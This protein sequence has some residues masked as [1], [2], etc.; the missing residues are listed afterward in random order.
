MAAFKLV[1]LNCHGLRDQSKRDLLT[2]F[3]SLVPFDV[4]FFQETH[5]ADRV[6]GDALSRHFGC[7]GH[8]SFGT[9]HSCGVGILFRSHL[10]VT[11]LVSGHDDH[12]RVVW[13][14]F[15]LQSQRFRFVNVYAPNVGGDRVLFFNFVYTLLHSNRVTVLGGDFNCVEDLGLDKAGGAVLAGALGSV[16]LLEIRRDFNLVDAF[17]HLY[18]AGREYTFSAQGV[19][20]RLDRFYVSRGLLSSVHAVAHVH[21]PYS[22]HS[23]VRLHF[24][25]SVFSAYD[26]GP[27]YWKCN[28]SVLGDSALR[29][30]FL[31]VWKVCV[32]SPVQDGTWWEGCKDRFRA[33]LR[34]HSIRLARERFFR[35]RDL[36]GRVTFLRGIAAES[37]GLVEGAL[38]AAEEE[39]GFLLGERAMGARVRARA[40]LLDTEERPTR[41]FFRTEAKHARSRYIDALYDSAG[42]LVRGTDRVVGACLSYYT[43]L[44]SAQPTVGEA[45]ADLLED[46]PQVDSDF[47]EMC[48]SPL[49]Y[50]ECWVAVKGM[51]GD[52]SPGRDGL[53]KEFY[54]AFFPVFGRAFVAM[55][56]R[57][58]RRGVLP[59][60][61]RSGLITLLCKDQA[62]REHLRCWRP[63]TLL[64]VDYKIVSRAVCRRMSRGV[65]DVVGRDQT[66]AI[67]GR[68][69]VESLRLIQSV[70]D[71]AGDKAIP[72]ALVSFDQAKAFDRVSHDYMF[73][74]LRAFGFGDGAVAWVRLLYTEIFSSVYVNGHISGTFPVTRSVRQGCGLSPLLYVLCAEPL[75]RRL[76]LSPQIRGFPVPGRPE[77]LKVASFAD[78]TTCFVR[79]VPS[80]QAVLSVFRLFGQA[81]GAQLNLDKCVGHW[82]SGRPLRPL[83]QYCGIPFRGDGVKCLG[84]F[85]SPSSSLMQERNWGPVYDKCVE[86]IR[87]FGG[88]SLTLRGRAVIVNTALCSRLWYL[89]HILLL[90]AYWLRRF[91]SLLF[92]YVWASEAQGQD[93]VNRATVTLPVLQ[94]GL[95]VFCVETQ[96]KAFR[97][98]MVLDLVYGGAGATWKFYAT[99]F[100]GLQLRLWAPRMASNLLPH[101]A[102]PPEYYGSVLGVFRDFAEGL[103]QVGLV[104]LVGKTR[105]VY[106]RILG[107]REVVPVIETKY[108][109]VDFVG[110]WRNTSDAFV[111]PELRNLGWRIVHDVLPVNVKLFRQH[112]SVTD[113]CPLCVGGRETLEHLFLACPVVLPVLQVVE[114]LCS[115]VLGGGVVFLT[116]AEVLFNLV[117]PVPGPTRSLLLQVLSLYRF[118]VWRVRNEVKKE[119]RVRTS[120]DILRCFL[121]RLAFRGKVD[122]RRLTDAVFRRHWLISGAVFEERGGQYVFKL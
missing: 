24:G 102:V 121:G 1:T 100:M 87:A 43:E 13:V 9:P 105:Q 48:A 20:T 40:R 31:E 89:G 53:P 83:T 96:L 41:Y 62:R 119:H 55:V 25:R 54:A 60:S 73:A 38:V 46:L 86:G 30:D 42:V 101:A 57:C 114:S 81:S 18:P 80:L 12:G 39:L 59:E 66:C 15:E 92:R 3:F 47:S 90:S 110:V 69:I 16:P 23:L 76:R 52:K 98:S 11:N 2:S 61:L 70:F 6:E 29:S 74:V 32:A 64:N 50:E 116:P 94:G 115:D 107:A 85:F 34:S 97:V 68:S 7:L 8:W 27:G 75:A 118:A 122:M 103:D 84:V 120:A 65:G 88:R 19:S 112:T 4:L 35:T 56:N 67:P 22:D 5:V 10:T 33:L 106:G 14:D 95:G 108:P 51:A 44:L 71:Y 91:R 79:D 109:A 99:Y 117:A 104:S 26:C 36:L 77:D 78:D 17:R 28:V 49:T 63:L 82:V 72:C 113:R 45:A 37:P 93:R 21:C 111:C 58:Y